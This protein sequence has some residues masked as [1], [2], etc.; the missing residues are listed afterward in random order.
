MSTDWPI[1]GNTS[2][3]WCKGNIVGAVSCRLAEQDNPAERNSWIVQRVGPRR[4]SQARYGSHA[5]HESVNALSACAHTADLHSLRRQ[6]HACCTCR[7]FPA[8]GPGPRRRR[9][10]PSNCPQVPSCSD[11]HLYR[12]VCAVVCRR[13]SRTTAPS[14]AAPET[15]G[16]LSTAG[17]LQAAACYSQQFERRLEE[18][19]TTRSSGRRCGWLTQQILPDRRWRLA[20]VPLITVARPWRHSS[21]LACCTAAAFKAARGGQSC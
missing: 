4:G 21:A 10:T 16:Q 14:H 3:I 1:C 11:A 13:A 2:L 12:G 18:S 5:P 19:V 17:A 15:P 9:A 7:S 8:V 6:W 20:L